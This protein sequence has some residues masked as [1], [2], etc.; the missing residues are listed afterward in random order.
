MIRRAVM[1]TVLPLVLVIGVGTSLAGLQAAGIH[2][3]YAA[4]ALIL[5]VLITLAIKR[6]RGTSLVGAPGE[7]IYRDHGRGSL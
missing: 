2:W 4:W 6:R 3:G 1:L 5:W 7:T